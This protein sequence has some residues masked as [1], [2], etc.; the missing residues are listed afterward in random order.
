M[1]GWYDYNLHTFGCKWDSEVNVDY[2][3]EERITL[4]ADTPWSA[5][6]N[7]LRTISKN[8]PE[9]TFNLYAQY[10]EG[11]WEE[12]DY[13]AGRKAEIDSGEANWYDEEEE[14]E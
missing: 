8:Y 3:D 12:A 11:F 4:S 7:W 2:K 10:E 13:K 9:L 14:S 1:V 5:P 6:E